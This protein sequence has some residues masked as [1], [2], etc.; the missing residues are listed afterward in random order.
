MGELLRI[1]RQAG[2]T[3]QIPLTEDVT[4]EYAAQWGQGMGIENYIQSGLFI[5]K[6]PEG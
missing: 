4:P 2:F 6:K 5:G 1:I 3:E